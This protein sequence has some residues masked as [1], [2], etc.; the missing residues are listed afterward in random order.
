MQKPLSN[1]KYNVA[2]QNANM[3]LI[4]SALNQNKLKIDQE[5]TRASTS[6]QS[7]KKDINEKVDKEDGKLLFTLEEKK[8]LDGISSGANVNVQPDWN[9]TDNTSDSF[10]QNKPTSLPANG[11]NSDTVNK[12]TVESDVPANAKFTDTV[13]IHPTNAGNKH[14]PSGGS[15]GQ[16]LKWSAD[17]TA[18]WGNNESSGGG[19]VY[20]STEPTTGLLKGVVWI[21]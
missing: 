1:E 13:Y 12:H 2:V 19:V 7:L 6:E 11:G 3:D 10:I 9:V 20:E 14:I 5:I 4:D 18:V 17:G 16:I 8:K 15:S 21:Q